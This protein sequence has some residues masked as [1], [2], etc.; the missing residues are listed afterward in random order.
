M[1]HRP[2]VE[3]RGGL[4]FN[5]TPVP[6]S[7]AMK[8]FDGPTLGVRVGLPIAR[9]VAAEAGVAYRDLR[10]TSGTLRYFDPNMLVN[11]SFEVD[12]DVRGLFVGAGAVYSPPLLRVVSFA[13]EAGLVSVTAEHAVKRPPSS[14][15]TNTSP[16]VT[17]KWH[18]WTPHLGVELR[19]DYPLRWVTLGLRAGMDFAKTS[20]REMSG[21]P[22]P[23]R[24]RRTSRGSP[25]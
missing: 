7:T 17:E 15:A 6:T 20:R 12:D 10:H 14:M 5:R 11:R 8:P 1:P 2:Y 9:G 25:G 22:T 21:T 16:L 19:A 24:S 4:G 18:G 23:S 13:A 3:V